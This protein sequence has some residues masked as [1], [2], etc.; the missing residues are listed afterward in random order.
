MEK[1]YVCEACGMSFA[2]KYPGIGEGFIECHH[3]IP[4]SDMKEGE[5]R[6]LNVNDFMIL[7]SNCHKMIHRLDN[8]AD[9]EQLKAILAKGSES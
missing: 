2:N 9:L 6:N 5:K 4:Y 1:G 3:K 7:C 8:P